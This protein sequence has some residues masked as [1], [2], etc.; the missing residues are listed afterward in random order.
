M[1]RLIV[2]L[3][4]AGT[5]WFIAMGPASAAT[6]APPGPP[7]V[8]QPAATCALLPAPERAGCVARVNAWLN[9]CT[10]M[11]QFAGQCRSMLL[12]W[13][14]T[15]VYNRCRPMPDAQQDACVRTSLGLPATISPEER[16]RL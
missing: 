5:C 12:Q 16:A 8:P 3:L 14:T 4:V 13:V 1:R 7:P 6:P 9:S 11:G 10:Q 15:N 2:A